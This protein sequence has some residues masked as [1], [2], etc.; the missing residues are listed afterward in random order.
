MVDTTTSVIFGVSIEK[1]KFFLRLFIPNIE[2]SMK[3]LRVVRTA[4]A[5]QE[6]PNPAPDAPG[7]TP[8]PTANNDLTT[9]RDHRPSTAQN[10]NLPGRKALNAIPRNSKIDTARVAQNNVSAEQEMS[11]KRS[12][13]K[14]IVFM[15]REHKAAAVGTA[16]NTSA[17]MNPCNRSAG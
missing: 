13:R 7:Q 17:W 5:A 15:T 4:L 16:A 2:G 10:S 11:V 14:G 9:E 8:N 1:G 12:Q 3:S 6:A